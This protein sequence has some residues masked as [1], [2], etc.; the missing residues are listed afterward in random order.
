MRKVFFY[1]AIL[2]GIYALYE[3]SKSEPN[4]WISAFCIVFFMIGLLFLSK[5]TTSNSFPDSEQEH[6]EHQ[7]ND[8]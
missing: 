4:V 1:I 7:E 5:K 2:A 8:K 6:Q 3:Q